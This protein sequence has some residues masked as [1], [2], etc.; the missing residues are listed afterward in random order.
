MGQQFLARL[1]KGLDL[2]D[3]ITDEFRSRS[4][5]SGAFNL[6]GALTKAVIGFYD[7]N[8][9]KYSFKEFNEDLEIVSCIGNISE[10]DGEVFAHAHILVADQNFQ[11]FGGHLGPGSIIFASELWGMEIPGHIMRR[12][13]DQATGLM[14]WAKS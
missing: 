12:E 3:A 6:I 7:P 4:V 5:R 2:L 10:K 1:P 8:E 9:Q 13:Y 11:C 14:L